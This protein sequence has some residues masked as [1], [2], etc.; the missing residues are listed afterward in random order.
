MRV[1]GS[2]DRSGKAPCGASAGS[3]PFFE[4]QMTQP[5][6]SA[7]EAGQPAIR[8]VAGPFADA[9]ERDAA[10]RTIR[11]MGLRDAFPSAQ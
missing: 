2:G 3:S 5:A 7:Q 8:V 4:F 10:L 1:T 11:D 9:A 6:Q